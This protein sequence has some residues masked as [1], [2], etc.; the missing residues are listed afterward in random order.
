MTECDLSVDIELPELEHKIKESNESGAAKI[1]WNFGGTIQVMYLSYLYQFY[2][3]NTVNGK[4]H[5]IEER[6]HF[7]PSER[8]RV[9][10]LDK[11]FINKKID[12]ILDRLGI[13]DVEKN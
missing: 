9:R 10:E 12:D 1:H 5:R 11:R 4:V 7:S 6:I 2:D 8:L 13:Q 3:R